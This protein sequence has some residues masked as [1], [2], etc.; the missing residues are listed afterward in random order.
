MTNNTMTFKG[1]DFS[2]DI[3]EDDLAAQMKAEQDAEDA[4]FS[5]AVK[6]LEAQ[7]PGANWYA[8]LRANWRGEEVRFTSP[9]KA[10]AFK[11]VVKK[12]DLE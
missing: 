6:E 1:L 3:E 12:Y 4:A 5:A 7:F 8:G 9:E 2:M 10:A 11:A